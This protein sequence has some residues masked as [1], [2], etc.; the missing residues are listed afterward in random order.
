MTALVKVTDAHRA[1][2]V[3]RY[4]TPSRYLIKPLRNTVTINHQPV[5]LMLI[6]Q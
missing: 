1:L 6:A 4:P 3:R 2:K 5:A